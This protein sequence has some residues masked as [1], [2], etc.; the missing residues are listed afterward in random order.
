MPLGGRAAEADR[1]DHTDVLGACE[2]GSRRIRA[3]SLRRT[4][5]EAEIPASHGAVHRSRQTPSAVRR[6][7][8][9]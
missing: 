3:H 7:G 1:S 9:G 4:G 2:F 6:S 5:G 8:R